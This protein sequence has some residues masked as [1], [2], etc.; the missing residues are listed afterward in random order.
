MDEDEVDRFIRGFV[1]ECRHELEEDHNTV[2]KG[3]EPPT[4]EAPK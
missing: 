2:K 4:E 1:G 3:K